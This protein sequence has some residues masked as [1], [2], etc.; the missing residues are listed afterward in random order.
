MVLKLAK[1]VFNLFL[2]K[3][4]VTCDKNLLN[5]E[6]TLC[7]FCRND[8]PIINHQD[9]TK[10]EMTSKFLGRIPIQKATSFLYYK[11]SRKN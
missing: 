5:G 2:P 9:Y 3:T 11:K 8:L 6:E 1:T 4:C 7:T 10:N